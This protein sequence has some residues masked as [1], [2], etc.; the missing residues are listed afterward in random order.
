MTLKDLARDLGVSTSTISRVLNGCT[1]NFTIPD[2][3]RRR[4]LDHVDACGYQANPVFRSI[5]KQVNRQIAILFYSRSSLATGY[6]VEM[7][8]DRAIRFF[9][10]KEYDIHFTFNRLA[11]PNAALKYTL[12]PWRCAGLLIPDCHE[13]EQLSIIENS[14]IPYVCMNGIAGPN[15]STVVTDEV[16]GMRQ[17]FRHLR[18][19]GHRR[20][21]YVTTPPLHLPNGYNIG[22]LRLETFRD[23]SRQAGNDALVVL[24]KTGGDLG[25]FVG[26]SFEWFDGTPTFCYESSDFTSRLLQNGIT[27]VICDSNFVMELLYWSNKTGVRIPEELSIVAYNDLPFLRRTTPPVTTFR[28]PAEEMGAT[29]SQ[30][31]YRKLTG[32]AGEKQ[33]E[34]VS[35]TGNLIFRES[36]G[37]VHSPATK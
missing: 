16:D 18:G 14:G 21:A 27:A 32:E 33:N 23:E 5:R 10:E 28:I 25:I 9:D 19:L 15:G 17:I 3:L 24:L 11:R 12:P 13:P 2:E 31:L 34:T 4:I 30:L 35:L 22:H 29:A 7:M 20:I 36:T 6:T 37:P 1:K 8:V 26:A